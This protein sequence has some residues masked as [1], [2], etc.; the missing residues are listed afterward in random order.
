MLRWLTQQS[1]KKKIIIIQLKRQKFHFALP[2]FNNMGLI[3]PIFPRSLCVYIR[4]NS[5]AA[6]DRA[7]HILHRI[8]S[9]SPK[10]K[11]YQQIELLKI[12]AKIN[13]KKTVNSKAF[14]VLM[15]NDLHLR[16]S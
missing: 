4:V 9:K 5:R 15:Y 7:R 1:E 8:F 6:W 14:G 16:T 13:T 12:T 11:Q 10:N 2:P 3:V